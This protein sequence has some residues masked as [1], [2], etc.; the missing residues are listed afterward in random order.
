MKGGRT[1]A[2][3]TSRVSLP[4][5]KKSL[6]CRS[7][8]AKTLGNKARPSVGVGAIANRPGKFREEKQQPLSNFQAEGFQEGSREFPTR[9]ISTEKLSNLEVRRNGRN[10]RVRVRV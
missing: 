2:A 4:T 10:G 3:N 6:F 1:A 8:Q 7:A 9:K 5:H